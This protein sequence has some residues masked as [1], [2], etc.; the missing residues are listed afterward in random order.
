MGTTECGGTPAASDADLEFL[1]FDPRSCSRFETRN[2]NPGSPDMQGHSLALRGKHER[3]C[4]VPSRGGCG[5]SLVLRV[6]TSI[7]RAAE[8]RFDGRVCTGLGLRV[9]QAPGEAHQPG[10]CG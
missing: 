10:M 8:E 9:H 3:H 7:A 2:G 5:G 4:K 1:S 6:G